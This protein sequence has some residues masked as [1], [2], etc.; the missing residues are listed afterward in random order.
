[1]TLTGCTG[2]LTAGI[3][4]RKC[5]PEWSTPS[6]RSNGASTSTYS[7]VCDPA[8]WYDSPNM[9]SMTT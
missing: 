5:W 4:T 8:P 3:F 6:P 1:M 7:S 2:G 9:S